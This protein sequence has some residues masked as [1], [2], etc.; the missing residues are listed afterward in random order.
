MPTRLKATLIAALA[1]ALLLAAGA[2]AAMVG[3][4]RNSME[5]TAQRAQLIKLAGRDCTRGGSKTAL[6]VTLGKSTLECSYRTPVVGRNLEVGATARLL[7]TTPRKARHGAYLG[8]AL[9]AGGG[10]RY[11]M[12]VFPVQRK[13]QLV[14][15]AGDSARYL[16]VDRGEQAVRGLDQA[17]ALRLRAVETAEPGKVKITAYLGSVKVAEATDETGGELSGQFSGVL[18]GAVRNGNGIV[19]SIDDVIVRVPVR[20]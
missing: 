18:A 16:A 6:R 14:K 15:I 13:V 7:S 2:S 11:E 19:A 12:L 5:T 8:L 17:N 3:I 9:R 10:S 1:A 4:Y 20:F